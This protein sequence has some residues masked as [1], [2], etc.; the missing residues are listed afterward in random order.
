[1]SQSAEQQVRPWRRVDVGLVRRRRLPGCAGGHRPVQP[2]AAGQSPG[3]AI[4]GGTSSSW[5]WTTSCASDLGVEAKGWLGS[6][7]APFSGRSSTPSLVSASACQPPT[8]TGF[9]RDPSVAY[10]EA[11]QRVSVQ[12]VQSPTPSWGLD[13][14][15]LRALPLDSSLACPNTGAGVTA[16]VDR[17]RDP[18]Q[19]PGLRGPCGV[20]HRRRGR[21]HGRRRLQR[22]RHPRGQHPRRGG[23][24]HRQGRVPG[25]RPGAGLRGRGH[26]GRRDRGCRLGDGAS[27]S[28]VRPGSGQRVARWWLL[29]GRERRRVGLGRR[30]DHVR[31]G[32]GQRHR[33]STP[34]RA[35]PRPRPSRSPWA[36]PRAPTRGLRTRTS[37]PA[38]TCSLPAR[39]SRRP[40]TTPTPRPTP[41]TAPRWPHPTSPARP[42]S[43][44][45]RLPP[46]PRPRCRAGAARSGDPRRRDPTRPGLPRTGCCSPG[47]Y[48]HPPRT[49]P[50]RPRRP[51]GSSRQGR[52]P[53]SPCRPAPRSVTH[54]RSSSPRTGSRAV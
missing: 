45:P 54:N 38:W 4:R 27:S 43:T 15:D 9:S 14:A 39:R 24:R 23:P 5:C 13:R 33:A 47:T 16:Y 1:M 49:S 18:G 3:G 25:R 6:S 34:A 7:P 21:R 28:R 32:G 35:R 46:S 31:G 50:S 41:S 10:V 19:S 30:R 2:P 52:P 12:E 40:G 36:R 8:P 20:G 11:N 51:K 17:H 42:P 53:R 29:P 26:H 22:P 48:R 37:G 44:S